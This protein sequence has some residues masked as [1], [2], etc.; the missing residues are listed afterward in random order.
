MLTH[1]HFLLLCQTSLV[2]EGHT[3]TLLQENVSKQ[4]MPCCYLM[5][6]E[7]QGLL[8]NHQHLH[9]RQFSIC[10]KD[11][12]IF[13]VNNIYFCNF[14][15]FDPTYSSM[16]N[17]CCQSHHFKT[18]VYMYNVLIKQIRILLVIVHAQNNKILQSYTRHVH[19][20][21]VKVKEVEEC[22]INTWI[23]VPD[24]FV[25]SVNMP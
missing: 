2:K 15:K 14:W 25:V 11:I 20:C 16:L 17:A 21:M 24:K 6:S 4:C 23:F 12:L 5:H 18:D 22:T 9:V 10:S 13:N 19:Y 7:T 3:L 8:N 1:Q